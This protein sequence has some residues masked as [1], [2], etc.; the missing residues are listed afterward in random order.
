MNLYHLIKKPIIT[1]KSLKLAGTGLFTF[2]VDPKATKNQI[3]EAVVKHFGV[4]VVSV[5][6]MT[7]V[8]KTRRQPRRRSNYQTSDWKKAL[9]QLAPG[10]KID[11][12]TIEETKPAALPAPKKS[13]KAES[14]ADKS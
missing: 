1:E 10:Q 12:F 14:K 9:V 3:K 6:T 5:H 7:V 13:K 11:L 2:S 4:K 8:G